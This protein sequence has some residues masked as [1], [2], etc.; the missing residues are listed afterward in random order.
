MLDA[1]PTQISATGVTLNT[2]TRKGGGLKQAKKQMQVVVDMREFGSSLPSVLHQ[3]GMKILPV[4]LE[5][6]DYILS[7]DICVERKSIADL[8]QSFTSGRL[9]HQAE[10]MTRYYQYPVLLIEFSQDKSFSLQSASDVGE[11]ILPANIISKLSLLVL[12]FPRLRIVW[13]RSLHATADIF[14]ALKSNQD[15]PDLDRAM[16]VGVPTEDGLIEGDIRAENFNTTAV[17]LL[18]RLPGVS[19]A[20]YRSLMTGCKSIAEMALLSVDELAELMGGKQP[21]RMLRDFLDAKCP[22]LM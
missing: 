8:F 11:D 12:H 7:P 5:V 16:R 9:H 20:N 1:S 10:T 19:D 22:T 3:Q 17:E 14:M 6:G 4:T 2:S 18:R 21:A 13:S 15:E